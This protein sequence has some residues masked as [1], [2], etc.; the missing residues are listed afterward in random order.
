[1]STRW[2]PQQRAAQAH[3]PRWGGILDL[4]QRYARIFNASAR[5]DLELAQVLGIVEAR[6]D[7]RRAGALSNVA[8]WL[9][10]LRLIGRLNA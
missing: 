5:R 1:V 4:P 8:P 3:E 9:L 6:A 7:E 10:A 2:S